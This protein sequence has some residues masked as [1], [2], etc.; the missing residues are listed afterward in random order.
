MREFPSQTTADTVRSFGA[1]V[2]STTLSKLQPAIEKGDESVL[3]E[4]QRVATEQKTTTLTVNVSAG[5]PTQ[6]AC[7]DRMVAL[8]AE[9]GITLSV[10]DN[11]VADSQAAWAV[12]SDLMKR[13]DT[14]LKEV[15]ERVI[16]EM[17]GFLGHELATYGLNAQHNAPELPIDRRH[18]LRNCG[19]P[20][21]SGP[22]GGIDRTTLLTEY[23]RTVTTAL[24]DGVLE[25]ELKQLIEQGLPEG[26]PESDL[27]VLAVLAMASNLVR[28][29][30]KWAAKGQ[31]AVGKDYAGRPFA[32]GVARQDEELVKAAIKSAIQSGFTTA[33]IP[34]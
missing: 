17:P 34:E 31:D 15:V 26:V 16:A 23:A 28:G 8:L 6:V 25:D 24:T 19:A 3:A 1:P 33:T 9:D 2:E 4:L 14:I 29:A 7:M 20:T 32:L 5:N 22:D 30:M 21:I 10:F 12:T 13:D 27:P 11:K 18:Y